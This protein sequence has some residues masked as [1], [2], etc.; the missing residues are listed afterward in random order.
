MT[1]RFLN[2]V[3]TPSVMAAQLENGSRSAYSRRDGE[4]GGPDRLTEREAQFI[5]TRDSFYMAT[6]GA[7][8]WPY[9]QHRGGPPG[10]IK[11]LDAS[12]VGLAGSYN[13]LAPPRVGRAY[14]GVKRL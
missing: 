1:S 11:V 7:G 13:G 10:F 5:A 4:Q 3:F 12:R 14:L 6:V 8:G 9:I 2:V